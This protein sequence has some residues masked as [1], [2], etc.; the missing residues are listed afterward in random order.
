VPD[1]VSVEELPD[2]GKDD[3]IVIS[4]T[5]VEDAV[6]SEMMDGVDEPFGAVSSGV[7]LLRS[8]VVEALAV[9]SSVDDEVAEELGD[10]VVCDDDVNDAGVVVLTCA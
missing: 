1:A 3:G 9:S 10:G 5:E 2:S 7:A 6:E 8:G 4:T